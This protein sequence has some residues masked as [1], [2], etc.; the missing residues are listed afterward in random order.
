VEQDHEEHFKEEEVYEESNEEE[1]HLEAEK[2][3]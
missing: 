1:G 2:E 3:K